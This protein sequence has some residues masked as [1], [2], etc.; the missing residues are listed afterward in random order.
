MATQK[1]PGRNLIKNAGII[2]AATLLSRILGFVRDMV[3]AN[4]LGTSIYADAFFVAFRIPNLL[5][6][7]FGEG[8]LT[9]AFV[10][11]FSTYLAAGKRLEARDIAQTAMTLT[12]ICLTLVTILGIIF[13]PLIISFIAPGFTATPE[14]YELA[15]FLNRLMFPYILLISLVALA[16]GILNAD[17]HFLT[18]AIAPVLL[19][20]CMIGAALTLTPLLNDASL[21]L[22]IGVLAG[23]LAQLLLQLPVLKKH[24]FPWRPRFQFKHPA[25]KRVI[26]LMGPSLIGL[27]ITQI[28]IF[29]NTLLASY[30]VDGSI[31]YLYFA[32]RLIQFPLGIFAV[33][34]GTA[35]LPALSHAAA[36]KK[37]HDFSTTF[38][39]AIRLLMFI[40]LPAMA[41]LIILSKPVVFLLFERGHFGAHSTDMVAQTIIAYAAGLWAY[42][43][44][45]VIVPAFHSLQDTKTPVKVGAIA[46]LVNLVCAFSL[47]HLLQHLGLALATAISSAVNCLLLLI[48]L[49]RRLGQEIKIEGC[50]RA[51]YQSLLATTVMILII[52]GLNH[53]PL[54]TSG[55]QS[56][57]HESLRLAA[58]IFCGIASYFLCA[59]L[60]KNPELTQLQS[61]ITKRRKRK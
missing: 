47:M 50:G 45:R 6:R 18:P 15:V 8:S 33:A 29:F 20:I 44:L 53:L 48:L 26:V 54:M 52:I 36:E 32:D 49:K 42:A 59:R 35:I 34:L 10:P 5:R 21:A 9:A 11:V 1:N 38:S 57:L 31:S 12:A 55:Y 16:M 39:L 25:I 22:A 28:T 51:F 41:G 56:H 3:T 7:L 40:T 17:G 2:G 43:A 24:G 27:G 4:Y 19:N 23:G 37:W 13:S 58:K 61:L 46:L 60:M 30:L 14:K